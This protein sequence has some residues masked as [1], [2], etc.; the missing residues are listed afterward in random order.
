MDSQIT[1]IFL[2][3]YVIKINIINKKFNLKKLIFNYLQAPKKMY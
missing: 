2:N 3:F 1:K